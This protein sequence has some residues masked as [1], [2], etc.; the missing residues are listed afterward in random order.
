MLTGFDT[1][2]CAD[3]NLNREDGSTRMCADTF[4]VAIHVTDSELRLLVRVPSEI[5]P[6]W[7]DPE[8]FQS[9]VADVVWDQLNREPVLSA[10]ATDRDPGDTVS[11]GT[12]TLETDGTVLD[13]DLDPVE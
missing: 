7:T 10:I 4:G 12:V 1:E 5:D 6:G 3:E 11:L 13:H 9:L 8:T 2:T